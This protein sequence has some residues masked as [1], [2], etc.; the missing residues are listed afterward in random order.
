MSELL[1]LAEA[2]LN[3]TW[4]DEGTQSR[5]EAIL[6]EAIPAVSNMIGLGYDYTSMTA[7]DENGEEF[8]Y[9][10]PSLERNVL[11]NYVAYEWNHQSGIF[12]ESYWQE[13]AACRQKHM[14][15]SETTEEE[16]SDDDS[17]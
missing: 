11:M 10:E 9:S 3:I 8:D 14:E 17:E 5:I 6:D 1:E 13:I 4:N 12:R 15:A 7:I 16:E 2:K